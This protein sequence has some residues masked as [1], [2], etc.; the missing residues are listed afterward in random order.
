MAEQT[1]YLEKS[2][3]LREA[4]KQKAVEIEKGKSLTVE[5]GLLDSQIQE[6]IQSSYL[7]CKLNPKK[8]KIHSSNSSIE[9]GSKTQSKQTLRNQSSKPL[10]LPLLN[11]VS[12]PYLKKPS[13]FPQPAHKRI[14][15]TWLTLQESS[16]KF[17][18]LIKLMQCLLVGTNN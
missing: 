4:L 7:F 3:A 6:H 17:K 15:N 13:E 14:K 5:P 10:K 1:D 11:K 18:N 9:V 8:L 16:Q 12:L 2:R